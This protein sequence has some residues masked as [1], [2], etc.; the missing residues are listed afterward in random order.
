MLFLERFSENGIRKEM[1]TVS[2]AMAE[3]TFAVTQTSIGEY[4]TVDLVDRLLL[5]TNSVAVR[6]DTE[7]LTERVV[8]CGRPLADVQV[9]VVNEHGVTVHDRQIGEIMVKSDCM[10]TGY[11]ERNDLEPFDK[12]GWYRTGDKGYVANGEVYIIGRSK[13]LI[14]NAGKNVFPQD[15]EAIVNTIP[16]IHPG[17]V[18]VFGL[19]DSREGTELICVVAETDTQDVQ[20][21]KQII[22]SVRQQVSRQSDVTVN[23]VTLV[24]R[25]WLI[26]TSSGK[27]ARNKNREKWMTQNSPT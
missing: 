4:P 27:I 3:N 26:K 1:L 23:F 20:E 16:G 15:I 22:Q 19:P 7:D 5:T 21:R 11:Y 25:G 14:I 12:Y 2:Y 10:L 18:V 9:K 17:R 24:E 8:S 13:D 6:P